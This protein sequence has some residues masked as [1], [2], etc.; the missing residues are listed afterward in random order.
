M[1]VKEKLK[2][3]KILYIV[4]KYGYIIYYNYILDSLDLLKIKLRK[5]RLLHETKYNELRQFKNKYKGKR[6]FIIATGPS[7]TVEDL[8]LLKNEIT[9]GVN[10]LVKA[11]DKMKY[12][13]TFFGIQD[14]N[15]YGKIGD[16]IENCPIKHI[17]ISSNLYKKAGIKND[18]RYIQYPLYNCGH[19]AHN[20]AMPLKSDF[21]GNADMVV[22]DGYS[23]TY[24]MLQ[25]AVYMGFSEIYL[26]GCDCTYDTKGNKQH[27]I[28]SGHFDRHA[29]SVGERMIYAYSVAKK[30]LDKK[31]PSIKIFN[32]TRG[33]MLEIFPRKTL[34]EINDLKR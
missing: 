23:V 13:P 11:L 25:I 28:E 12:V 6:C 2:A 16:I 4:G 34:D 27:F 20:Y 29:D 22:Y 14:G 5:M 19:L 3:N 21:S 30:V 17:F 15:V 8:N 1:N 18:K 7:L 10:S 33:G 31:Y 26:L 24:S 9:I 32:A